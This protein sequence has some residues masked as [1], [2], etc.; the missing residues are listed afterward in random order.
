MPAVSNSTMDTVMR[1]MLPILQGISMKALYSQKSAVCIY[2]GDETE[3]ERWSKDR[4]PCPSSRQV[5]ADLPA[6]NHRQY[7]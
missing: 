6:S 7:S 2:D 3:E 5:K 4:P 1:L